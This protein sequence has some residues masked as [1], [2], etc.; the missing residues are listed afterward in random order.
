M[1]GLLLY[2]CDDDG[3][4][5][6]EL[7]E[8]WSGAYP[9]YITIR[10]SWVNAYSDIELSQCYLT[11]AADTQ[12]IGMDLT[13]FYIGASGYEGEEC[14]VYSEDCQQYWEDLDYGDLF[15]DETLFPVCGFDWYELECDISLIEDYN[16]ISLQAVDY[17]D[18]ST[19]YSVRE[20]TRGRLIMLPQR[21][22]DGIE[23]SWSTTCTI[24][25]Y[26]DHF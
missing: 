24:K 19:Q 17:Q 13:T 10:V 25:A 7:Q 9:G 23:G 2:T 3:E 4:N 5:T 21:L 22:P 20:E 12:E 15:Y 1:I 16:V 8:G 6:Y 18:V 11:D 14:D 26:Y